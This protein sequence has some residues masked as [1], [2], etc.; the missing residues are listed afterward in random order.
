MKLS[1][2]DLISTPTGN[3]TVTLNH[4]E[5]FLAAFTRLI[6]INLKRQSQGW[7]YLIFI[8]ACLM[9]LTDWEVRNIWRGFLSHRFPFF[10][11]HTY[12]LKWKDWSNSNHVLPPPCL[13]LLF[14]SQNRR[15]FNLAGELPSQEAHGRLCYSGN[16]KLPTQI[17]MTQTIHFFTR[18]SE[19]IS[20]HLVQNIQSRTTYH[21]PFKMKIRN[22]NMRQ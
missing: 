20:S 14:Y 3:E 9:C 1:Q 13:K 21:N 2:F 10:M 6:S 19:F 22:E 15:P 16:K 7:L 17:T 4:G 11:S 5:T 12:L 8:Q 18:Y